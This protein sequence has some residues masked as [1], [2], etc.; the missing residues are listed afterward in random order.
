M[1]RGFEEYMM[2][3]NQTAQ[4]PNVEDIRVRATDDYIECMRMVG[5]AITCPEKYV[6][7]QT[8]D[9]G[10]VALPPDW[11]KQKECKI[12]GVATQT[13]NRFQQRVSNSLS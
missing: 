9:D 8:N 2:R 4:K 10:I 5:I 11:Q 3:V 1:Y 12:D 7:L 13:P 6:C